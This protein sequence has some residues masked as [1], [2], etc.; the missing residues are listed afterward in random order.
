MTN[1]DGRSSPGTCRGE[2]ALLLRRFRGLLSS[3]SLAVALHLMGSKKQRF[4]LTRK[5]ISDHTSPLHNDDTAEVTW[6]MFE[7][8]LCLMVL[9]LQFCDGT[10]VG[11]ICVRP[12]AFSNLELCLTMLQMSEVFLADGH[13]PWHACD[14]AGKSRLSWCWHIS[15]IPSNDVDSNENEDTDNEEMM[16]H[17]GVVD[18]VVVEKWHSRH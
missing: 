10:K 17:G 9:P 12:E 4:N 11:R 7:F 13:N 14:S 1:F 18:I 3:F 15:L 8:S 2:I 16:G 5:A 6:I